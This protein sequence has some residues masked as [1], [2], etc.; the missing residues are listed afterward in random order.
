LKDSSQL[1][2]PS[3]EGSVKGWILDLYPEKTGEMAVWIKTEK[4]QCLKIVDK[5][6]PY[7]YVS[8]PTEEDLLKLTW[9]LPKNEVAAEC[10]FVEKFVG[11]QDSE[12]TKVLRIT[13]PD[14]ASLRFLTGIVWRLGDYEKYRLWNMDTPLPQMYLYEKDLFPFAL[15]EAKAEKSNVS[16]KLMD[17]TESVDYRIPRLKTVKIRAKIASEGALP[18]FEDPI[19]E[20]LVETDGEQATINSSDE[21]EKILALVKTIRKHDPDI[22]LSEG[23]D[24]FLFTYLARRALNNGVLREL[25]L[26]REKAAI[27]VVQKK[28]TTY[29]SYGRV[30]Y[31]AA[32]QRLLGRLH[33]DLENSGFYARYGLEGLVEIARTC[34]I[35]LHSA[36]RV[37]IG[38]S[39]K[40]VQLYQAHKDDVLVPWKKSEPENF[41]NARDLLTADRGGFYFEP[42]LGIHDNVGEIDFSSMYPTLMLK[43]NISPETIGCECCPDSRNRVP[44]LGYNICEKRVGIIP[45]VLELMLKKRA[46]YKMM[47]DKISSPEEKKKHD[48]RQ[49]AYKIILCTCFGYMGYRN[50]RFGKVDAFNAACAFARK[51]LLDMAQLAEQMGFEIVHGIVDSLYLKKENASDA[52][53]M[54]LCR[55]ITKKT[56][57]S[58]SYEGRYR[59]IVF[60]PS[61]THFGVPVLNRF[62]GVFNDGKIKARGIE[63]RRGDTPSVIS[64]CQNEII[65]ELTKAKNSEEFIQRI[66][67]VFSVYRKY[68]SKI[69]NREVGL[70]DLAL[71]KRMSKNPDEYAGNV[72]Q[73]VAARQL[74]RRG[75][76]VT[77]GQ[78]VKYVILDA[79]NKRPERRI[80]AAQLTNESVR[81]DAERY[82][83]LLDDALNNILSPF[84]AEGEVPCRLKPVLYAES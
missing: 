40:S 52:D 8:A 28:G 84:L 68:A 63:L 72:Q 58:I 33:I 20:L 64:R 43:K 74:Q 27:E 22:I 3:N 53:F 80:V 14:A 21:G 25:E 23:G 65:Q 79:D 78:I 9:Y 13:V 70:E 62:Y 10:E 39:M 32:P 17:S 30:Y 19:A 38:T 48:Q 49:A 24:T 60:L 29:F 35:P 51:T 42:K 37:T 31:R 5:W 44:E 82:L 76:D 18:T 26:G 2:S 81:Y 36:S 69:L 61:K 15:V 46:Y 6:K 4:G 41:K 11:L 56:G 75:L 73:A 47:R 50:A 83:A 12:R 34:R 54:K 7:F 16:W 57:L 77:A 66:S 67:E 1:L 45:K 55:E 71:S 59:W